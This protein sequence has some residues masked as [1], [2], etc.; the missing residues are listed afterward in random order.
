[1][2]GQGWEVGGGCGGGVWG[3][4]NGWM[5]AVGR[6]GGFGA[7]SIGAG[8][9]GAGKRQE[10][11]KSRSTGGAGGEPLYNHVPP[12]AP[13][14]TCGSDSGSSPSSPSMGSEGSAP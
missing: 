13:G 10:H 11:G 2:G 1:M 9:I 7:G 5:G 14:L 8:G 3:G 12:G 4:G 6:G